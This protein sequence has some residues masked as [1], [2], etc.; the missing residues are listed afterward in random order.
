MPVIFILVYVFLLIAAI[1]GV[2][3]FRQLAYADRIIALL[4]I[5]TLINELLA[6]FAMRYYHNNLIIY[7][8]YSPVELLMVSLYFDRSVRILRKMKIAL[9]VGILGIPA[10]II[11]AVYYQHPIMV[12]NS[13]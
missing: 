9:V 2:L 7:H 3:R 12:T 1:A 10:S 6:F 5:L 13:Y 8:I 4:I 11:N